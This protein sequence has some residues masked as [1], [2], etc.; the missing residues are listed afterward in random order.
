MG[1]FKSARAKRSYSDQLGSSEKS[2]RQPVDKYGG[3]VR[4]VVKVDK[5]PVTEAFVRQVVE[6]I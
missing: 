5:I 3:R 4:Y 2:D 6:K 1:S